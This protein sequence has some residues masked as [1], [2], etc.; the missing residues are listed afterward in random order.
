MDSSFRWNDRL[1]GVIPMKLVLVKRGNG[2]PEKSVFGQTR[3]SVHTNNNAIN[4]RGEH[5]SQNSQYVER[6]LHDK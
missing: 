6:E 2:N 4:C 1:E 5:A 3:G